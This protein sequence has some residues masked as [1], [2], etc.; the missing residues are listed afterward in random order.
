MGLSPFPS[1]PKSDDG[2]G[3][4][5]GRVSMFHLLDV[6]AGQAAQ[7]APTTVIKVRTLCRRNAG[8]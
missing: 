4:E 6:D 2:K 8:D 7:A 5:P 3:R 1:P